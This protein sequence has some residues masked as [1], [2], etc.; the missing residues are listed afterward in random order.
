MFNEK[1]TPVTKTNLTKEIPITQGT[2]SELDF[3]KTVGLSIS[4][5]QRIEKITQLN[6]PQTGDFYCHFDCGYCGRYLVNN[7][8]VWIGFDFR[9]HRD[10]QLQIA[11]R[12]PDIGGIENKLKKVQISYYSQ[13]YSGE[14][15]YWASILLDKNILL[16]PDRIIINSIEQKLQLL[17]F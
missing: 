8:A 4:Q 16:E 6:K 15:C 1:F 17:G 12:G 5:L 10:F 7:N 11:F 3:A 9:F 14:K 13:Y 2:Q